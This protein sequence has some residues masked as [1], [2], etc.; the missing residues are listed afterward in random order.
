M[1]R[2][3][4]SSHSANYTIASSFK[5]FIECDLM[6]SLTKFHYTSL[7]LRSSSSCLHLLPRLPFYL[8]FINVFRKE[9]PTQEVTNPVRLC[10]VGRY[11]L[12]WPYVILAFFTRLSQLI[13][14]IFSSIT[15]QIFQGMFSLFP[16][17]PKFH[18][19]ATLCSKPSTLLVSLSNLRPICWWKMFSYCR[20]L[21]LPWQSWI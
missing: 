8:S 18:H 5:F 21:L 10:F 9:D 12:R 17:V 1:L 2:L 4:S 3:S 6:F 7:S 16:V 14:P 11:F 20:L 19:H 13:F 15:F